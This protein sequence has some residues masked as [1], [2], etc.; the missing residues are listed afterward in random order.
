MKI[1]KQFSL[2]ADLSIRMKMISAFMVVA[3]LQA[4]TGF[5]GLTYMD[6]IYTSTEMMFHEILLPKQE[7]EEARNYV[8]DL[9][10]I[11]RDIYLYPQ[12]A[13]QHTEAIEEIREKMNVHID[14]Y[15][16]SGL[17][18]DQQVALAQFV[19][20]WESHFTQ[21]D[22]SIHLAAEGKETEYLLTLTGG[23]LKLQKDMMDQ[24]DILIKSETDT[25]EK[26]QSE[27]EQ[28]YSSSMMITVIIISVIFFISVLFGLWMTRFITRPLHQLAQVVEQAADG[29]LSKTCNIQSK[30]ETGLLAQSVNQMIENL[31]TAVRNILHAAEN[32]SSSS[33]QV[34]ANTEEIATTSTEQAQSVQT[35]YSLFKDFSDA[36]HSIAQKTETSADYA[37]Q[38]INMAKDGEKV[39]QSSIEGAEMIR[40]QMAQLEKDTRKIGEITELI[41][42][43]A[44]QTNLLALNA[45]IEAGRAGEQG[46]GFAVVAEEVRKLAERSMAA[47]KDISHMIKN[48]QETTVLNVKS[49]DESVEKSQKSGTA[50]ANIVDMIHH[51]GQNVTDIANASEQQAARSSEILSYLEMILSATE[52]TA[53][54]SEETA[55]TAHALTSLAERLNASAAVFKLHEKTDKPH[56]QQK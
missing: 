5:I 20:K 48:I 32:L 34:S 12:Q 7:L 4:A 33:E 54:S 8:Q 21:F 46:R 43:I 40:H 29:D 26:L 16:N 28:A 6:K 19:N 11:S 10:R 18:E 56:F 35:I 51:T 25:A 53:A 49:V 45:A 14:A 22:Q 39:I 52:E 42:D 3:L 30:D 50:L 55:S 36:F 17:T 15:K 31:R 13:D 44:D 9:I 41:D 47:T 37:H 1:I 27:A 24:L 23:L 38:T 2:F